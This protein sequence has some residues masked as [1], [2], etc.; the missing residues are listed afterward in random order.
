MNPLFLSFLELVAWY[1]AV[2]YDFTL[3]VLATIHIL[4]GF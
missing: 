4:G 3:Y 1:I 2:L